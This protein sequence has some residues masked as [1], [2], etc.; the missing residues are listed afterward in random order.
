MSC[1]SFL[2]WADRYFGARRSYL[3]HTFDNTDVL[4]PK[5]RF[6]CDADRTKEGLSWRTRLANRFRH[7]PPLECVQESKFHREILVLLDVYVEFA[8]QGRQHFV[9]G[10]VP[11]H[12]VE[13][14]GNARHQRSLTSRSLY[15]SATRT[16][17][18]RHQQLQIANVTRSG[19]A[20]QSPTGNHPTGDLAARS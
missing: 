9:P 2:S 6:A 8:W 7:T 13:L 14:V 16:D 10:K 4:R 18:T 1:Y 5:I 12:Q 11:T 3:F 15:R 20:A 17:P 19:P